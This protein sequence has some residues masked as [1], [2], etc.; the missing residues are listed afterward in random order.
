MN[1]S[2]EILDERELLDEEEFTQDELHE[3]EES[4]TSE[5][6][7]ESITDVTQI[8]LNDIGSNALLTPSEELDLAR[9]VVQGDF[10]RA[11]KWLNTT[12]VWSS[13]SQNTTSTE[14]SLCLI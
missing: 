11:R 10:L 6:T 5:F 3:G 7:D 13:I 8:Y 12:C 2:I 4:S 1:N 9:K 14:A